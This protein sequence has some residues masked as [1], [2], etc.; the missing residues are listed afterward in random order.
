MNKYVNTGLAVEALKQGKRVRCAD[1]SADKKFIF[2]QVA[3]TIGS[4]IVP[5]MQSLPQPVKDYFQ[6]T[7]DSPSEQIDS[8]Y[9]GNQIALVGL[10]NAIESYCPTCRDLLSDYWEILD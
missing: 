1:W 5:K 10:S 3:S 6:N 8:I 2:V 9:Y 7:F 4:A